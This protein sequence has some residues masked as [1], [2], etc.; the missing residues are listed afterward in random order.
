MWPI[1]SGTLK[2]CGL[3]GDRGRESSKR[4]SYACF[5]PSLS[6]TPSAPFGFQ[7]SEKAQKNT[8]SLGVEIGPP[9]QPTPPIPPG[10][11]PHLACMEGP[12]TPSRPSAWILPP[13]LAP[14]LAWC[15]N[16][17]K[18]LQKHCKCFHNVLSKNGV[19]SGLVA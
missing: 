8:R 10:P 18:A 9:L 11:C 6:G 14:N 19:F 3:G 17:A 1:R 2:L 13:F 4:Q 7:R 15:Q 16:I 12:C 5:T